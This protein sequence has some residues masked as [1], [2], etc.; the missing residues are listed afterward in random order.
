VNH[1]LQFRLVAIPD[2][3]LF[4]NSI[5]TGV[6]IPSKGT[7]L[8]LLSNEYK[9]AVPEVRRKMQIGMGM[10]Y[11]TFDGWTSRQNTSFLGVSAYFLDKDW[12]HQ[13]VL[14]GLP[15]LA[16]RNTGQVIREEVKRMLEFFGVEER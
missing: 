2:F 6:E 10:I 3:Q 7:I 8:S 5:N 1:N 13:T 9:K 16:R 15:P 14:L 12:N 11:L 4:I